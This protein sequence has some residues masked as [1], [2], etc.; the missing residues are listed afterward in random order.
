MNRGFGEY[1]RGHPDRLEIH[2]W[3]GIIG[4]ITMVIRM[5]ARRMRPVSAEKQ[6]QALEFL[7]KYAFAENAFDLPP[8][9]LNRLA[10]ERL[11]GVSGIDGV[12]ALTVG[13]I[14]RGSNPS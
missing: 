9:L 10:M 4:A 11:P 7:Q 6:S 8:T 14:T 12:I 3:R 5:A 1:S 2:R 13:M